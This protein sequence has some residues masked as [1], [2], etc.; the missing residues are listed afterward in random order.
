MTDA[1]T[2]TTTTTSGYSNTAQQ[3]NASDSVISSDFE[4]FLR[5][6][7]VQMQNQDPLNP[8]DSAD[9]AVQ[10]ATFSSVEQQVLTND[11]L[12]SLTGQ[13]SGAGLAQYAGWVGMDAGTTAP[14]YFDGTPIDLN[15][16]PAAG[17]DTMHIV[18]KNAAG[19]TVQTIQMN[20]ETEIAAWAGADDDGTP[21]PDGFYSF[22]LESY[23]N[24]ALMN[25]ET[26]QSYAA[27]TEARVQDGG[28]VFI[29]KGGTEVSASQITSLRDP[30]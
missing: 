11:L 1:V 24:G 20:A 6:L 27:I 10:L 25:T 2:S 21:L 9:Y 14:A 13:L 29:L 18:V 17:A 5:M 8:I 15:L 30:V 26:V 12:T 4:T 28:T 7:T 22:E 3:E 23:Q 16:T 19:D